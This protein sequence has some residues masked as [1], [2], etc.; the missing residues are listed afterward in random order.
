MLPLY[1]SENNILNQ[2]KERQK[3]TGRLHRLSGPV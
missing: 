2:N 3:E 1:I